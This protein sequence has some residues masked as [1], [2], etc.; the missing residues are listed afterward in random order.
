MF[1][2][3]ECIGRWSVGV[4]DGEENRYLKPK[5]SY[6]YLY[7]AE[8]VTVVTVGQCWGALGCLL[9]TH[10]FRTCL[11]SWHLIIVA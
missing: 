3:L 9:G 5:G 10:P 8:V 7:L 4:G 2:M 11:P 1:K 6:N